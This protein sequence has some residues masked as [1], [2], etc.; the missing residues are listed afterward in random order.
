MGSAVKSEGE[1]QK[2]RG[3]RRCPLTLEDRNCI[4][5][6]WKRNRSKIENGLHLDEKSMKL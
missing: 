1:T 5:T 2:A 6:P 4:N 3:K